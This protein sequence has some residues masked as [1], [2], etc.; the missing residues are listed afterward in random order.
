MATVDTSPAESG[1]DSPY[2]DSLILGTKWSGTITWSFGTTAGQSWTAAEQDAFRLAFSLF[3]A[4]ANIDF[5][6]TS[7]AA[8][9]F[10]EFE[11]TG[12]AWSDPPD[13][14]T[15]ADHHFPGIDQGPNGADAQGR[16]NVTH[17]SWAD[18]TRG[19]MAFST[20]VHEIG[21]GVGLEH[22]HDGAE[23][24]PG[25]ERDNAFGDLGDNDMN[26]AIWSI[27]SYN[28]GWSGAGSPTNAYG[29][30]GGLMALDIAAVQE[31]Y[32]TNWST[33]AGDDLYVLPTANASGTYFLCIWDG[34]GVDA[35]SHKDGVAAAVIDLR[36]APLTGEHAGGYV[37]RV[38]GV[39]GGFTIANKVL[40]ESAVGGKGADTITGNDADNTIEGGAGGDLLEGGA[41]KD[42][43]S[44]AGS[45]V[46]VRVD[47][48]RPDTDPPSGG[49]AS[50][51]TL[52]GFEGLLGGA[53]DDWLGG[54]G[55]VG[56]SSV[57][58]GR[59]ADTIFAGD[60]ADV[61][62]GG[63]GADFIQGNGGADTMYGADSDLI[64]NGGFE[65]V[66]SAIV[67][68]DGWT[69]YVDPMD[70]WGLQS[71]PGRELFTSGTG[72][73]P[74][75]GRFGIDLEGNQ[76]N[77]NVA[78]TQQV[79]RAEDGVRYRLAFE[80]RKL[81]EATDA[82]LEVYWGGQKLG[83]S[84][85]GD[86]I[87]P[88]A[89][90]LTYYI[91]VF[92]GA[93]EGFL[94]NRLTFIEVGGGDTHG[95]LLDNIRMY[96]VDEGVSKADDADPSRDGGDFFLPGS[97]S[98]AVFGHGGDDTA[99]F[100]DT[101]AGSDH[102]DGGSGTDLLLMDW[103]GSAVGIR[104]FGLYDLNSP[105]IGAAEHYRNGALG[106][107]FLYFKQVERFD[108]RG[109]A[110][111]DELL[112]GDLADT[113]IGNE[114][115]DTLIGGGGADDLR[116]GAG[117]DRAVIELAGSGDNIINLAAI[118]GAGSATLADGTRL[119]SIEALQLVAGEGND[120]VDV[121]GTV[122]TVGA[123]TFSDLD[124]HGGNDT[125]AVDLW[126]SHDATLAG[127]SGN[128]L[129]IIDWS[130]G[131][132]DM[133]PV[134]TGAYRQV[135]EAGYINNVYYELAYDAVF[136][137]FERYD[138][139]TGAGNDQ[140][141]GGAGDDRIKAKGGRDVATLGAGDDL[142]VVDWAGY[143]VPISYAIYTGSAFAGSLAEGYAGT[144]GWVDDGRFN[145]RVDFS[146]VERFDVRTGAA[147]DAIR[148]GDGADT[149][150]TG[151]GND[152]LITG[153]GVD[154][155][156]GGAGNDRWEA[157]KSAAS[158]AQP[159]L[160]DLTSAGVQASY[161]GTGTVRGIEMLTLVTGAGNDAIRTLGVWHDDQVTTGAG[162]DTVTVAGGRDVA[163][164]GAGDDLL[165]V[166][167]AGYDVP[168]SY[169]IYTGSA[170]TGSLAEGYGGTYGWVDDGRFNWRVDFSGVERFDVRTGAASDA[171]RTGDGADTV[172]TGDGN[173]HLITGLGVDILDGGAGNDRWEAD[174][175]AASAAQPMLLD[176]TSTGAQASY[177]GSGTVR[178]I[179][180]LTL[181][182]GAGN[183]A[184]RTLG[185]WH[186]DQVTT[187]A[188]A[189]T[190]T[191]AGGRDV[192]ALGEGDDLLVVDW[193]GYDVPISYG[194]YTG[195]AFTGSLAEGYAGTY[196]WVDDGRFNWRVDF[197]GVERFDVR[198]GA[199]SDAI[200]TGD[201]AD[202][203]ATGDGND[204][205]ITGHGADSIQGGLGIDRWTADKAAAT[206][207]MTI[208]LM[209]AAASGY[210]INGV[211][212]AV[213]GIEALGYA[214]T[215]GAR[216]V[217]GSGNDRIVTRSDLLDDYIDAGA[218]NDRVEVRGG[219]DVAEL[220]A[221]SDVLAVDW[222][223]Y[224]NRIQHDGYTAAA[225]AGSLD[226]G[227][228]GTLGEGDARAGNRV[229][230][231]GVERFEIRLG[232]AGDVVV[233]GDGAD[234][235]FG[236]EGD[237]HLM[238]GAG[239]DVV[240]GGSGNDRWQADKST[241]GS[242]VPVVLDLALAGIQS[243][244]SGGSVQG[245]EMLSLRTGAGA[246]TIHTL[247]AS[248]DD[249]VETGAGQDVVALG[250]GRDV[251]L[252]GAG[253]DLLIVDWSANGTRVTHFGYTAAA[254]AGTLADGYS[255][256][257]GED[258]GR[259]G[260]RADFNGVERFDLHLGTG[261]DDIRTGDGADTIAGGVGADRLASFGGADLLL[262][263]EANDTLDAGI[264]DDQLDGGSGAD[265]MAGG[266]GNDLY[267]VDEGGDLVSDGSGADTVTASVS[268]SLAAGLETLRLVGTA[269]N[270]TGNGSDN[271]VIGNGLGNF[272]NGVSGSDTLDGADGADTLLGAL[273]ADSLFGGEGA[274]S[275]N[276]ASGADTM[277]GGHGNDAYVVDELLDVVS[278]SGGSGVDAIFTGLSFTLATGFENLTLTGGD[279]VSGTG[280]G[281]ANLLVGN[282]AANSLAGGGGNDSLRG[283]NGN[284]T[285]TG[286]AGADTM[287]GGIGAD[288]Y[289][290]DTA[291]DV[292]I[293]QPGEGIDIV[294]APIAWTL[295]A[296]FENLQLT[297]AAALTGIGNAAINRII[298]N[299][300]HNRLEGLDSNDVLI[301]GAGADTL[302]G[303]MGSD[304]LTGGLGADWFLFETPVQGADAIRDFSLTA[305]KIAI[306]ASAFAALLPAGALPAANFVAHG[307]NTA[308]SSAGFP[309]FIYNTKTG[310]LFFDADGSEGAAAVRLASL[311]GV[312]LLSTTDFILV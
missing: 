196:G 197:S 236:Q 307:A 289:N 16:Y 240:D 23:L 296:E 262:G 242:A 165:V 200:R 309:Q 145:W 168:I 132:Y 228:T 295:V 32:G 212:G 247:R 75:E 308:T 273:G 41:G 288:R 69:D 3:E 174:K 292:L 17:P 36:A 148:T 83:W 280:N 226:A 225:F 147:S 72:I 232:L 95:T 215:D 238:T 259:F 6:E 118:A 27:M 276:G 155:V 264:G 311:T 306:D 214:D 87:L 193:A 11:V 305:D 298:G 5:D 241:L 101:G 122:A 73:A 137:G 272:I 57:D 279:T 180:M 256:S 143:D 210:A 243:S 96:R 290:V 181:V 85:T 255:G 76:L 167:W 239:I 63:L 222:T 9:N 182:T 39:L 99:R 235:V 271:L 194:I 246:D 135:Y 37:S 190:V 265:S 201:G 52:S 260:I 71:G 274:D 170:F 130:A 133:V 230:F 91:D 209:V 66:A 80:A 22:P 146:G 38:S 100:D 219:R 221:G 134:G 252:L 254:F 126:T 258:D 109:G 129:L 294:I 177:M 117:F 286:G 84:D 171:I 188:G 141:F 268:A 251:A 59:G 157:D 30:A 4:V 24:F 173:D 81:N 152:H 287:A 267:F 186:D 175:S 178:G 275:L 77:T 213:Q 191:V 169:G 233:T 159:M 47:L 94:A 61:F 179:E 218:G 278:E 108:L 93:G 250:G 74:N 48:G 301:G 121:R 149:V 261:D 248:W 116:G 54:V 206:A 79:T 299:D 82:K 249:Q 42:I 15:L 253:S 304:A 115:D 195:S 142:L 50:G 160:L 154:I 107:T 45:T 216:F 293:E 189:D 312:P 110:G 151:D 2:L 284:D 127:G 131:Q 128:D 176:L 18:V 202:T 144:Y 102:F 70:G 270:G 140:A 125:I 163:T 43:V 14:I 266:A 97:G 229:D 303:G 281:S 234:T 44:Y 217:S 111:F 90:L 139:S 231:R 166:D 283:E 257:F 68:S 263:G 172:A 65:V 156:D 46:G 26:Q 49:D 183:D 35:I 86:H 119:S 120:L 187:S 204:H 310:G 138:I 164:L 223:G 53:G 269:L 103:S 10:V 153:L 208:N 300:G 123:R 78:I 33:N 198:T 124:G 7:D 282:N 136:T 20:I 205:L 227:Y 285:L 8:A 203:V 158:E 21:H 291:L 297:G 277:I 192:V 40:I 185:V 34:A 64:A 13:R 28:R 58:G 207:G 237:D 25:V 161:M 89:T 220:G 88:A 184:I 12:A 224:A 105:I 19:G 56:G 67:K 112:G 62:R 114:G 162:A 302:I 244:Y 199:A 55:N 92:G 211:T 60:D 1:Y 29:H 113:L 245:I 150:A 104:H 31:L 98:D 51:D 106:N